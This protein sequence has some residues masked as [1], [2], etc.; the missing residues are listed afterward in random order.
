MSGWAGV[1]AL[2]SAEGNLLTASSDGEP[3][4]DAPCPCGHSADEH[5]A[6]AF[7]YCE[8]TTRAG[9]TRGCM[10]VPATAP[11]SRYQYR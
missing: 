1:A 11:P 4:Q 8:A 2:D 6:V 10:C 3:L 9:L 5:D 7:R